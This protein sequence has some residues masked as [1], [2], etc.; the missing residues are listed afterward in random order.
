M[1]K[2]FAGDVTYSVLGWLDKNNDKLSEDYEK[3]LAGSS[4]KLISSFGKLP[5]DPKAAKGG[6]GKK[7]GGAATVSKSFLA[8]LKKLL[9]ALESTDAHFIRCIKPNNELRPNRLYGA[10]VLNQLKCSGTLEAVELM[11]KGYPSRIPYSSIHEKYKGFMPPC[12][13]ALP[14]SEFVEAIALAYGVQA[15]DYQLGMYKIFMRA[16][17][18]PRGA[19]G[20]QHRRDG[21]DHRQEDQEFQPQEE[22]GHRRA[23]AARGSGGGGSGCGR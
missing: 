20:R 6:R 7:G 12:V 15:T 18:L 13:Q 3:H 8:S 21:A 22:Q 2:H 19:Q 16:G 4:K 1:L 17:R 10:F 5:E 14:P 9:D 23:A 11:Q